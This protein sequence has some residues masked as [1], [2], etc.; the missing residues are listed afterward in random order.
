VH[1]AL[2]VVTPEYLAD[3][4]DIERGLY[5][6]Y[7]ATVAKVRRQGK[8]FGGAMCLIVSTCF[9]ALFGGSFWSCLAIAVGLCTVEVWRFERQ[10]Y[11]D[12][13]NMLVFWLVSGGLFALFRASVSTWVS[14]LDCSSVV[15]VILSIFLGTFFA[16]AFLNYRW[17]CEVRELPEIP[18][19]LAHDIPDEERSPWEED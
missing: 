6:E 2:D 16:T 14:V 15:P 18:P 10:R 5:E 7:A 19:F 3:L 11:A 17:F 12:I 13:Y 4:N 9:A 1:R 8:L